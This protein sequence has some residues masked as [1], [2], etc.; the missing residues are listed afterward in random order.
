MSLTVKTVFVTGASRGLGLSIC[1]ALL[2]VGGVHVIG[3]SRGAFNANTLD[4]LYGAA[5]RGGAPKRRTFFT[6]LE[7]V[8]VSDAGARNSLPLRVATALGEA[9]LDILVNCAGVFPPL[10]SGWNTET[11]ASAMAVNC[12]GALKVTR[13]LV[14]SMSLVDAHVINVTSGYSKHIG[15]GYRRLL[16][17]LTASS[18][19]ESLPFLPNNDVADVPVA[20][21]ISKAALNKGTILM[22]AELLK[23]KYKIRINAVDPGC[24]YY[25][26]YYFFYMNI[27]STTTTPF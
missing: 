27:F 12:L 25:Y 23:S 26:Y 16:D 2:S 1:R 3:T 10:A 5:S 19:V 6:P 20:Y 11:Y 18:D 24:A 8:D 17:S 9:R 14:P 13:A 4:N 22:A 15:E 21:N 7:D